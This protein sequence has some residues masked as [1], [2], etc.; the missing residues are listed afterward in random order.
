MTMQGKSCVSARRIAVTRDASSRLSRYRISLSP[1]DED[2]TGLEIFVEARERETGLLNVRAGD[3]A[4]EAGGSG[5]ELERQ[6][7]R[8]RVV[9]QQGRDGDARGQ[10]H[11]WSLVVGR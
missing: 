5:E 4:P 10:R 8:L 3:D 2:A 1:E 6:P 11:P 9:G 7:E